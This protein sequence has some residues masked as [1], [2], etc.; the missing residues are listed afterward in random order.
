MTYKKAKKIYPGNWVNPLNG[1]FQNIDLNADGD[2]TDSTDG[3]KGGPTSVLAVPGWRYFQ[4]FGYAE[5]T[6]TDYTGAAVLDVIVPSPYKNDDTRSDISGLTVTAS[7][8]EPAYIYR[9]SLS[10]GQDPLASTEQAGSRRTAD[11]YIPDV[12]QLAFGEANGAAPTTNV[13]KEVGYT[14][15]S[16]T[17]AAAGGFQA[18]AQG[19]SKLSSIPL[20]YGTPTGVLNTQQSY[21][22]ITTDKTFK[23][24]V[25]NT[26]ASTTTSSSGVF[27]SAADAAAGRKGYILVEL[28][29]IKP[30]VAVGY[31]DL[32]PYVPFAIH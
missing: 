22:R 28:C 25:K 4:T 23:I 5:V 27:I 11:V 7:T 24:H 32:A 16:G 1:W 6:A 21:Y 2:A 26:D 31:R 19:T 29:Y 12:Y 3:S 14:S 10:I 15:V 30:D 18:V 20:L 13:G 9:A 8:D 17:A